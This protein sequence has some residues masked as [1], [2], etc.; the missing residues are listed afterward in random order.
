MLTA[1]PEEAVSVAD[2]DVLTAET[3]AAKLTLEAP[4]GTTTDDGTATAVELLDRL[5]DCP[6]PPAAA[7]SVTVQLSLPAPLIVPLVQLRALRVL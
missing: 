1:P 5:T 6:L 2:C 4:A 3:V 7:F